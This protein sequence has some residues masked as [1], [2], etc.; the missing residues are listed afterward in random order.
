MSSEAE[1]S[2]ELRRRSRRRASSL[3]LV[4]RGRRSPWR[5]RTAT[6]SARRR[7]PCLL[8]VLQGRD[9]VLVLV[10]RQALRRRWSS[11]LASVGVNPM[12]MRT[13]V[14][15][16]ARA[17]ALP[18]GMWNLVN[19]GFLGA[20]CRGPVL[21]RDSSHRSPVGHLVSRHCASRSPRSS[22]SFLTGRR[23]VGRR[24]VR[25][26]AAAGS[27]ASPVQVDRAVLCRSREPS[28]RCGR[29][30]GSRDCRR[31][32]VA[33]LASA[34]PGA[35]AMAS[36]PPISASR[37]PKRKPPRLETGMDTSASR[38][39]AIP[40][41]VRTCFWNHRLTPE[42]HQQH[43][44]DQ[45]AR[46]PPVVDMREREMAELEV[47]V[48]EVHDRE[49]AEQDQQTRPERAGCPARRGSAAGGRGD[50]LRSA[51]G[52]RR[53]WKTAPWNGVAV[54]SSYGTYERRSRT[55]RARRSRHGET[56][57]RAATAPSPAQG[58]LSSTP[59]CPCAAT[60]S[61]RSA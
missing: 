48:R 42:H 25:R 3:G 40:A 60:S 50:S 39:A 16:A 7:R 58:V 15:M 28:R 29:V 4:V 33:A 55:D 20:A 31:P 13:A 18:A 8:G 61:D 38:I 11:A 43:A 1:S 45:G 59:R 56:D 2:E 24:P 34:S 41:K 19:S 36:A 21:A 54:R 22:G 52:S 27:G 44:D 10:G 17:I 51:P 46:R 9:A 5:R 23:L 14:G 47:R 57:G 6:G 37:K 53:S 26:S 49:A 30:L 35:Q 12:P 32:Y